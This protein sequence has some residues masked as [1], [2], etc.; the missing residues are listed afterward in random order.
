M[1]RMREFIRLG[2]PETVQAW[3]QAWIQRGSELLRSVGLPVDTV[4]A[5]DPFFGRVGKM[6]ATNQ[7]EQGLKFEVVV[8]ID[9]AENPT[10]IMSFNYHQDHF[11]SKFGILTAKDTVA[12]TAC[13]GF[14][15]ERIVLSLFKVHGFDTSHWPEVVRRKLLT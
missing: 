10:A 13:L 14:G 1:F 11:A 3:R 7:R 9:S 15:M 2:T 4:P 8:P 6:L 12:H 5:S